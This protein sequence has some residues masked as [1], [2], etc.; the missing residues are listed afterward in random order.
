MGET[1]IKFFLSGT[2][3]AFMFSCV[4]VTLTIDV[5]KSLLLGDDVYFK[6][7]LGILFIGFT[8]VFFMGYQLK[9]SPADS[10]LNIYYLLVTLISFVS[11]MVIMYFGAKRYILNRE[12]PIIQIDDKICCI[13]NIRN[14]TLLGHYFKEGKQINICRPYDLLYKYTDIYYMT[15]KDFNNQYR[16]GTV[17]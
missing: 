8:I 4:Y 13:T 11:L 5:R 10:F 15:E 12:C 1:I 17:N 7:F 3:L 2:A 14:N 6:N 16:E 9:R